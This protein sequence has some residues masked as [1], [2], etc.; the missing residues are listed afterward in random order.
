MKCFKYYINFKF[1]QKHNH[2]NPNLPLLVVLLVPKEGIYLY[3]NQK[4]YNIQ[5]EGK[6]GVR[7]TVCLHLRGGAPH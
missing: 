4:G 6:H 7:K 1:S 3:R 5:R 2:R